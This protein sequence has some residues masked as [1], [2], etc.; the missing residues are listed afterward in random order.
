M[1]FSSCIH[2]RGARSHS[3]RPA[4]TMLPP[5]VPFRSSLVSVDEHAASVAPSIRLTNSGDHTDGDRGLGCD[6]LSA[7]AGTE[8]R[9]ALQPQLK[10]NDD[11]NSHFPVLDT[12]TRML[13][14]HRRIKASRDRGFHRKAYLLSL[15]ELEQ[16]AAA[17]VHPSHR[18]EPPRRDTPLLRCQVC[19]HL[20]L[21]LQAQS[22][23]PSV[24]EQLFHAV[25]LAVDI[26]PRE[27]VVKHCGETGVIVIDGI[28]SSTPVLEPM[29]R[30][31][32]TNTAVRLLPSSKGWAL[33]RSTNKSS[34]FS[35]TSPLRVPRVE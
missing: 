29:S 2:D 1:P 8:N 6:L 3:N 7:S 10:N 35:P 11:R 9:V 13:A 15:E 17:R 23:E 27:Q 18:G 31:L 26:R 24:A 30:L 33:A 12:Y 14:E 28:V 4:S 19:P 32:A 20:L 21:G 16:I 22:G 25:A 5:L 34:A